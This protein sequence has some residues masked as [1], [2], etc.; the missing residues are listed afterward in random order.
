[1]LTYAFKELTHN[2]YEQI[3]G[4]DFENTLERHG[5]SF[6]TGFAQRVHRED[7]TDDFAAWKTE[8]AKDNAGKAVATGTARLRIRRIDG[9]Q[10][11]QSNFENLGFTACPAYGRR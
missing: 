4:E 3:A 9:K 6:E 8:S 10:P 7:G 2:N 1:M 11:V 5:L